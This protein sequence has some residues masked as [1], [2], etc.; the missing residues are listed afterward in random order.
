MILFIVNL[1]SSDSNV[2]N[3]KLVNGFIISIQAKCEFDWI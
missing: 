3:D 2:M 1:I